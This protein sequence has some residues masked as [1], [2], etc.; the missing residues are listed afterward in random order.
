MRLGVSGS[1]LFGFLGHLPTA[2]FA[3]LSRSS[4]IIEFVLHAMCVVN[5][6]TQGPKRCSSAVSKDSENIGCSTSQAFDFALNGQS[7][8]EEHMIRSGLEHWSSLW[9]SHARTQSQ[10]DV[11]P[12]VSVLV[13]RVPD[14]VSLGHV[15]EEVAC[16]IRECPLFFVEVEAS[17]YSSRAV[18]TG[19][20][21][22]YGA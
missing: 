8:D 6:C 19:A 9:R 7:H 3:N 22:F 16:E 1:W 20:A 2:D 15:P 13:A 5:K 14:E 21:W 17:F 10:T 4:I 12:V 18:S 11:N